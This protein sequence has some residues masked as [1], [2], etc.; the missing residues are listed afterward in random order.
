MKKGKVRRVI[1]TYSIEQQEQWDD[2]VRSF[3]K[4]DVYWLSGYV[5]AFMIHGDGT[6]LLITYE[7]GETRGINVVMK[8]DAAKHPDLAGKIPEGKYTDISTPYGYGGWLIEGE[9]TSKL[10][11]AYDEWLRENGIISEF[12]RF[13]P[14]IRNHEQCTE[15][16]ETV[17]LGGVEKA[18]VVGVHPVGANFVGGSA[19][20][21][22]VF[23]R[24]RKPER[25]A[26]RIGCRT[27]GNRGTDRRYR[28]QSGGRKTGRG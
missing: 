10:F 25:T 14:M 12:V 7:N 19:G 2:I 22:G 6:P 21:R 17:R 18:V 11:L 8:R 16:Y 20:S 27:E 26:F 23:C 3:G 9:E 15:Y 5:K 24:L 13:H 4:H 1:K 28:H